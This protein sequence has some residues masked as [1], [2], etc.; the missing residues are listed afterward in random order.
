VFIS[1]R[2]STT[3]LWHKWT[4]MCWREKTATKL[5][6]N[7]GQTT[8]SNASPGAS[9]T[10]LPISTKSSTDRTI[11]SRQ[12]PPLTNNTRNGNSTLPFQ[13]NNQWFTNVTTTKWILLALTENWTNSL[14]Q[15]QYLNLHCYLHWSPSYA[16]IK[17]SNC[18]LC[19]T[20]NMPI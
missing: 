11:A 4:I 16:M 9:S 3:F 10:P 18:Y 19:D 14:Q 1:S 6:V 2:L 15:R 7:H 5:S 13:Q 8:L 12:W 20:Q 17:N